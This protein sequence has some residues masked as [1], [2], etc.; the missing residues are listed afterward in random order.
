MSDDI[1]PGNGDDDF[2][3]VEAILSELTA[4][5][6]ELQAPPPELWTRIRAEADRIEGGGTGGG[7]P[8][9]GPG[10][11]ARLDEGLSAPVLDLGVKRRRPPTWL[12]AAAAAVVLLVFGLGFVLFSDDGDDT[13][14]VASAELTYDPD[15]FDPLGA[16]AAAT[17]SLVEDHEDYRIQLVDRQL[18]DPTG[19]DADLE[20]WLLEVDETGAVADLVSLG[21]VAEGEAVFAVPPGHDPAVY[22]V[23]D[24][25]VEP[26][27]GDRSHSGRSILRGEL[28]ET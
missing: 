21:L 16:D 7:E 8:L 22:S 18:P 2:A 20:L 3:D 5:D 13:T 1:R 24:I 15:A 27:D 11:Q 19:E 10:H 26:R 23:V 4:E 28:T 12:L 25:S 9:A 14:V 17:A 6:L